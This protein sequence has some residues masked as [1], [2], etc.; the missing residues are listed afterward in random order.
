VLRILKLVLEIMPGT[1]PFD[2]ACELC[3]TA[4]RVGLLCEVR[5]NDV[6]LMARPGDDPTQ[7]LRA[8]HREVAKPAGTV[9]IAKT[10]VLGG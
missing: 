1:A 2:A 3:Q 5:F 9:R 4:E 7:L 8:Y 6:K 10:F